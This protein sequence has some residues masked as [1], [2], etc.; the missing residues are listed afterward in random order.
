MD[1]ITYT[2]ESFLTGSDI[3]HA[4]LDYAQALAETGSAATVEI[5]TLQD[6]GTVSR[7]EVL[8]GPSSQL[9]ATRVSGNFDEI[10]DHTLVEYLTK[11]A[12]RLRRQG[13]AWPA[14]EAT[15]VRSQWDDFDL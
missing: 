6:D 7:A 12:D 5:P 4:L 11:E 14:A 1:R 2:A 13:P 15:P 3:A 10:V 8:V 9:M